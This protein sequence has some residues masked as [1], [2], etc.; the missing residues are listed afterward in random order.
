MSAFWSTCIGGTES[1]VSFFASH[2]SQI[3]DFRKRLKEK[4]G[5][6]EKKTKLVANNATGK[7]QLETELAELKDQVDL[8]ERKISLLQRKVRSTY[9][10]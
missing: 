2:Y 9:Q 6:L 10:R 1:S 3:E 5:L 7:R 8:K 4:E